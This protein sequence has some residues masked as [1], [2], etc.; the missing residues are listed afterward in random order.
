MASS[1]R[2]NHYAILVL[3]ELIKRD[4]LAFAYR[5]FL[6]ADEDTLAVVEVT[7]DRYA[8]RYPDEFTPGW[9]SKD[10]IVS[11]NHYLCDFSYEKDNNRTDVPLTIFNVLPLSDVRFWTLMWDIKHNY[12]H[13]DK[14]MAQ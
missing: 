10:Y 2:E 14:Y 9:R 3:I 8:I 12:G 11:T 7:A 5:I 6:V 1:L 13:I 4:E